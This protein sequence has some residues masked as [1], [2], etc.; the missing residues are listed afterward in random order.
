MLQAYVREANERST[1]NKASTRRICRGAITAQPRAAQSNV[2]EFDLFESV[3]LGLKLPN[4]Q[5]NNIKKDSLSKLRTSCVSLSDERKLRSQGGHKQL[6]DTHSCVFHVC[7]KKC[8]GREKQHFVYV[9]KT[10]LWISLEPH[11]ALTNTHVLP[12]IKQEAMCWAET[13]P[14]QIE[15]ICT[16]MIHIR[17][18]TH[19]SSPQIPA[20]TTSNKIRSTIAT[21]HESFSH[22]DKTTTTPRFDITLP[23]Y[24]L[25][26]YS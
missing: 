10:C 2:F 25:V 21:N 12:N 20:P 4:Y 15:Q 13:L 14:S 8:R 23:I 1:A 26:T 17:T 9:S 18:Y 7:E 24:I 6:E 22:N 11:Q 5:F 16:S 3:V 19:E